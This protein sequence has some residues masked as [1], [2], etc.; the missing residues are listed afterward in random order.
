[1]W[2]CTALAKPAVAAS[3]FC[4][5]DLP[6]L[7]PSNIQGPETVLTAD[8]AELTEETA[9]AQG[10]VRLERQNEVLLSPQL[11]YNR[12]TSRVRTDSGLQYLRPGLYLTAAAADYDI[13][14]SSGEFT[15]SDYILTQ[16][17]GRGEARHVLAIDQDHYT[18]QQAT[19][20]TCPGDTKAW[21]LKANK[22]KVNRDSGRATAYNTI[23][24]F[25]NVP[26]FYTP[27][28]NF[29]IDDRRHTG[30]L[31]PTVG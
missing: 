13:D 9:H 25:Y 3:N 7:A 2:A 22:L 19:Y 14:S 16:H 21:L 23:L 26:I 12:N 8:E 29:P 5:F 4:P 27:Y 17:G 30:L 1:L 10:N 6:P 18:L 11:S 31:T 28:L 20:T 24:R 15:R